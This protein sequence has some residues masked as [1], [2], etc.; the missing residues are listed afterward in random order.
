MKNFVCRNGGCDDES[1]E[2]GRG[3]ER[4]REEPTLRC[5]Q[6]RGWSSQS[7]VE[8]PIFFGAEGGVQRQ[9]SE[10]EA[11]QELQARDRIRALP[12]LRRHYRPHR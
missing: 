11:D 7:L 2:Y 10:R 1:G 5:V 12:S 6:E 3:T 4:G 9:R 8:D